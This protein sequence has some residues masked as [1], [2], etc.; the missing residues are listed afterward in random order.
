MTTRLRIVVAGTVASVPG[1]GGWTW[2]VLQW[3]L[4][5]RRL[6]HRV[7]W[8]DPATPSRRDRRKGALADGVNLRYFRDVVER[9]GLS[10][11]A[12]LVLQGRS[13]QVV[14]LSSSAVTRALH[15]ADLLINV[16]GI[17]HDQ[18]LLSLTR[19]R[20]YLDLDPAFTQLW[21]TVQGIDMGFSDHT[22]FVTI[23]HGLGTDDCD[24]PA[25]GLSWVST[26]QPVVL[27]EWPVASGPAMDA[28]TTVANWRG[29]GSIEYDGLHYGQKAHALRALMALPSR[30]AQRLLLALAIHPGEAGDLAAIARHGWEI[31]A[32]A[33]VAGDTD[34]YRAFVQKSKG[35]IGIAKT[36]YVLSRCGWFSD[37]SICYLASG[38]PVVAQDTGFGRLVPVGEGLLKFGTVDEAADAIARLNSSYRRHRRAARELAEAYFDSDK[39]L[40]RLLDAVA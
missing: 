30:T 17:L 23:G 3:V 22:H 28:L 11:D 36:G 12:A 10:G 18:E 4:G 26:L 14:G 20:V 15:S 40:P 7:L 34:S 37:R 13:R 2:V 19:R 5:L 21:H 8:I 6:G 16:S 32:P 9:F 25:C 39:V 31:V 33:R 35:E 29:Y 27:D 24:V 1:Q 38:R